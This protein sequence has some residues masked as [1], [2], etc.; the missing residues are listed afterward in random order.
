ML[1]DVFDMS[2]LVFSPRADARAVSQAGGQRQDSLLAAL[3][4]ADVVSLHAQLRPETEGMIGKQEFAA[5]KPGA[6]LITR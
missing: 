3:A 1:R 5:L 2:V 6:I 4:F